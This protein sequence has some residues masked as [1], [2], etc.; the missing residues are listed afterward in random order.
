MRPGF[1]QQTASAPPAG[2]ESGGSAA[3]RLRLGAQLRQL[4]QAAGITRQ[5]AAAAIR[6]SASK[7]TRLELGRT[8]TRPRDLADLLGLYGADPAGQASMLAL[9]QAGS[10][11]GW[12]RDYGDAVPGW[13]ATR[14]GLEQSASM[15][16]GY[17]PRFVPELLRTPEYARALL[18]RMNGDLDADRTERQLAVLLR[19]QQILH[20][21]GPPRV[22]MVIDEGAL[23]RLI[24]GP[25][26]MR[27]Q[28]GH[29]IDITRL[30]HVNI[31]VL[32]FRA[33]GHAA[34]GGPV[35]L[36][37]FAG[38]Q[39]PDVVCLE[40][41]AGAVYPSRPT[42]LACYWDILNQLATQADPPIAST[43][44]IEQMRRELSG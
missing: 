6:S 11:R 17:E 26:V 2:L 1:E 20:R 38:D 14:L 43:L 42:E 23:R 8:G 37:R 35:E 24:G 34:C 12:W 33:G 25:A 5:D 16:R 22:W 18:T 32:P 28:L 30:G 21:E 27:A 7:I 29:L 39:L 4:R 15:I 3:A 40:H 36:L 41:F 19:R 10:D 31:Q 9:A 44:T 13:Q